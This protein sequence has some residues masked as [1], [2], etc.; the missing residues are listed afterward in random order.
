[1]RLTEL[2]D[3]IHSQKKKM[4]YYYFVGIFLKVLVVEF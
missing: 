3:L 4:I 2:F 1:M